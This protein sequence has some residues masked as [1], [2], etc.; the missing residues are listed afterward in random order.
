MLSLLCDSKIIYFS[1]IGKRF[2]QILYRIVYLVYKVSKFLSS[3]KILIN[4]SKFTSIVEDD[5]GILNTV[6]ILGTA[7]VVFLYVFF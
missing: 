2:I 5:N 6:I 7:V 3:T 1:L 4:T